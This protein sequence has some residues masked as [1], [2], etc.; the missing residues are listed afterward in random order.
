VKTICLRA[1]CGAGKLSAVAANN[2]TIARPT[3]K[4]KNNTCLSKFN[5][6]FLGKFDNFFSP[7]SMIPGIGPE[8]KSSIVED[9]GGGAA[10]YT[11]FKFFQAA[12]NNWSGTGL[13]S[14][15]E[16]VSGTI[17]GVAEGVGAPLVVGATLDQVSAHIA[18]AITAAF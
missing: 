15:G 8:W 6:T 1:D 13:G 3:W 11:I 16:A 14:I 9:V 12:G 2:A 7:L 10:K 4:G 17:E 18:C 5:N